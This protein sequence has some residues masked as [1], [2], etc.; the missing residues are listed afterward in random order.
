MLDF[1]EKE[2]VTGGDLIPAGVLCWGY[3]TF[4]REKLANSE[5][6]QGRFFEIDITVETEPYAR[7]HIFD[8]V[9]DPADMRNSEEWRK[10]AK[11]SFRRLMECTGFDLSQ[12]HADGPEQDHQMVDFIV[13]QL[14]GKRVALSVKVEEG[15]AGYQDKNKVAEF[16]S[17]NPD[18]STNKKYQRLMS[19]APVM[20]SAFGK[21]PQQQSLFAPPRQAA[22]AGN[23]TGQSGTPFGQRA[24][25]A[26]Q[27][28]PQ[29]TQ[30]AGSATM[31]DAS[32]ASG[33]STKSPSNNAA[34]LAKPSWLNGPK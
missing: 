26:A 3:I 10:M 17:P 33:A 16:L 18:S 13:S 30:N 24:D 29:S 22:P 12:M 20:Q 9:C 21:G 14:E 4:K 1:R 6:S 2:E 11:N 15:S 25:Q 8:I 31:A 19:G 34:A 27:P 7:K 5:K 32:A 23:G 28:Q